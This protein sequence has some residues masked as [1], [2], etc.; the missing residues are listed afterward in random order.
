[1]KTCSDFYQVLPDTEFVTLDAWPP[2]DLKTSLAFVISI[3]FSL[4]FP[5]ASTQAEHL[6]ARSFPLKVCWLFSIKTT[7][8]AHTKVTQGNPESSATVSSFQTSSAEHP[9]VALTPAGKTFRDQAEG[10]PW[11]RRAPQL[12]LWLPMSCGSQLSTRN[13]GECSISNTNKCLTT[14]TDHSWAGGG[15]GQSDSRKHFS[16]TLLGVQ[17]ERDII[18]TVHLWKQKGLTAARDQPVVLATLS[19][20]WPS[21]KV[22]GTEQCHAVALLCTWA[23]QGMVVGYN[24]SSGVHAHIPGWGSFSRFKLPFCQAE[25]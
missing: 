23:C 21:S 3:I 25:M 13:P 22:G 20:T 17:I 4:P 9:I 24:F 10:P 1:M 19:P 5:Y 12:C 14:R 7:I 11:V 2:G 15:R 16:L 6:L 8:A 18:C